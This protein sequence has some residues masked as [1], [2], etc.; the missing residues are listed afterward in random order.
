M[1]NMWEKQL[2]NK[3]VVSISEAYLPGPGR[4]EREYLVRI[5]SNGHSNGVCMLGENGL[6]KKWYLQQYDR[7]EV[8]EAI[9]ELP[10]LLLIEQVHGT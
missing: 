9:K 3:S 6:P 10:Q 7:K 5:K 2:P 1:N 4:S 8:E